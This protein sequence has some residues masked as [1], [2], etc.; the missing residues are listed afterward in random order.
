MAFASTFELRRADGTPAEPP[1]LTTVAP[2]WRPGDTIPL[3]LK[4]ANIGVT[5][6][7][8]EGWEDRRHGL[9]LPLSRSWGPA[10][11]AGS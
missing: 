9:L 7:S 8:G 5:S 4:G 11:C 2:L 6:P 1:T 10:R 3:D